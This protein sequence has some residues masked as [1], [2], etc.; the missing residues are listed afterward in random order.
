MPPWERSPYRIPP[1]LR[2]AWADLPRRL[3]NCY[4]E[5]DP[6]LIDRA[7]QIRGLND[8]GP[9]KIIVLTLRLDKPRRNAMA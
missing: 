6:Y 8:S 2:R 5:C 7:I 4:R 9:T 1:V 3:K